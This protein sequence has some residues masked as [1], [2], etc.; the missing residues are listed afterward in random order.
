[1]AKQE[2]MMV[3]VYYGPTGERLIQRGIQL[4]QM[5]NAP[6][7]VLTVN[8]IREDE[9][10][11]DKEKY[12]NVWKRLAK[13]AGA[14][15]LAPQSKGRKAA[16]VIVETAKEKGVTQMVI[17]QTAQTRWQEITGGSFVNELIKRMGA[18]DL[19]IVAVQRIPDKLEE[20]HER[21]VRNYLA[22]I[23]GNYYIT[24]QPEGENSKEGI[25]FQD[26]H[27]DFDNGLFKVKINN[28]YEYWHVREGMVVDCPLPK[29]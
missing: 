21:G 5:L 12:Y 23:D 29:K 3:C 2:V 26:L 14:E 6:L 7:F 17:G 24:D 1:M 22:L 9:Y 13:E 15:F 20:T 4:S 28:E 16:E 18:I 27:T 10:Q 25:F 11:T 19:H 8:T